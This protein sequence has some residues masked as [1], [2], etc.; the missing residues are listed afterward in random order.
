MGRAMTD[1]S[2]AAESFVTLADAEESQVPMYARLCR[3]IADRPE[4][5]GL[6]LE[7]PVAQRLPVLLLAA[8]HQ[9]VLEDP[10]SPLARWF[11]SVGGD[12]ELAGDMGG[13][14]DATLRMHRDR[15][16]ATVASRQV[17]TNEVNRCVAWRAGLA[18]ACR[19]D[20]R[21]LALLELGS[22]AGL[23]L[24]VDRYLVSFE[25]GDGDDR[26]GPP[27]SPVRLATHLRAGKWPA[28]S[29][30]IPPVVQ[31]IGIDRSP[32]DPT[33]PDDTRWLKACVWPEQRIR[34]ERLQA[35]LDA[36]AASPPHVL[37][38]DLVDRI[39]DAFELVGDD[40]HVVVLSS[41]A[42]AYLSRERRSELHGRLSTVARACAGRGSNLT[43]LTLEADHVVP[44]LTTPGLPSDAPPELRHSSLLAATTFDEQGRAAGTAVARC[45]AHLAWM[46]QLGEPGLTEPA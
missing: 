42:L 9:T 36:T 26:V 13:A 41:W 3:A 16:R 30:P 27:D 39:D 19:G 8:L 43:V 22:S 18:L 24:G 20:D 31:R 7:A 33:D 2:Q 23:N 35:A 25:S 4:V 34:L 40:R 29:G 37:R 6:L 44:W 17:Q 21:P 11:P 14:L 10:D 38:G 45:Q 32:L 5:A 12:P 1:S 28:L 46:D 15:V